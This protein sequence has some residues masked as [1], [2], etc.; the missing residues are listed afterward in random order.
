MSRLLY[1]SNIRIIYIM[2]LQH[3]PGAAIGR[4]AAPRGS[5]ALP[6]TKAIERL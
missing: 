4:I 2:E 1:Q 6:G 5:Q 3:V